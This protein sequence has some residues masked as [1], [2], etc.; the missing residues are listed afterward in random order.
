MQRLRSHTFE[1]D[2][3]RRLDVEMRA[4]KRAEARLQ[5]GL[6]NLEE[7][8]FYCID[9]MIKE[10]R[11]IQRDLI[12][13]KN[14]YSKKTLGN[15]RML[16]PDNSTSTRGKS[17]L[18]NL[19]LP[20]IP[21]VKNH[22]VILETERIRTQ[23]CYPAKAGRIGMPPSASL[24]LQTQ[25]NDFLNGLSSKQEK[26]DGHS[27][28]EQT[29]PVTPSGKLK[30][31][32]SI[33]SIKLSSLKH[34]NAKHVSVLEKPAVL[35]EASGRENQRAH[36]QT[37]QEA[38]NV[39]SDS[40]DQAQGQIRSR[41]STSSPQLSACDGNPGYDSEFYAPDGLPRT[42]HTMP[43]FLEA[44]A[45]AKKARYIRHRVKTEDER[46]LSISE[47]FAKRKV[48]DRHNAV[49]E[50]ETNKEKLFPGIHAA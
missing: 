25:I 46:E 10:Q 14:G 2:R 9:R 17:G 24:A 32:T 13:I 19:I 44:F 4:S 39:E 49:K 34:P 48:L 23:S 7:A 26:S 29:Q 21:G 16:H 45:E 35:D 41:E 38:S 47:I 43:S 42:M 37:E 31:E 40:S 15:L 36:G 8:R 11:Q 18:S 5:N 28:A 33:N 22:A 30:T 3:T 20:S 1:G 50:V 27:G 12:R 6:N